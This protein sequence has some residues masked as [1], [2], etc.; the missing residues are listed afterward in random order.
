[1]IKNK[2]HF[3]ERKEEQLMCVQISGGD[4]SFCLLTM[5]INPLKQDVLEI[6]AL[7]FFI[8]KFIQCYAEALCGY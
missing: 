4:E 3:S 6:L 2:N 8:L 5:C 7:Q 1:M